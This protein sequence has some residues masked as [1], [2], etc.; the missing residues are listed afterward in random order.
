MLRLD[1]QGHWDRPRF[2][3]RTRLN[4]L[5]LKPLGV[6]IAPAQDLDA[7]GTLEGDV[8]IGWADRSLHCRGG[9]SLKRLELASLNSNRLSFACKGDQLKLQPATLRFG[10]F[11]ARA[12]GSVALNKSFDLQVDVRRT[13]FSSAS[14]DRL[15]LSIQGPWAEPRWS[16]D[17][18]IQLPESTG[19]NTALN[20][21]GQWRIPW[22]Q[23]Q[24][25]SVAVDRLRLSAPGLRFGLAGTIGS[26]LDLRSTELQIC[27]LY[28]SPSPR[29]KR[30][31]RMPSSA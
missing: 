5:N 27:L 12:S 30:Q 10:A 19:L 28:T 6:V 3:L 31:S 23:D 18:E 22:L 17:G 9:L 16:A 1:G 20:L 21:D 4:R 25:P 24:Q 2:R 26:Q 29:D 13:D 8:Q 14:Q 15:K 11:E 7:S